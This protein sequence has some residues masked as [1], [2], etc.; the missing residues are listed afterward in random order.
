MPE[1]F[2][3]LLFPLMGVDEG[4]E[5]QMQRM[6]TCKTGTN[7]RSYDMLGFRARGGQRPGLRRF[8]AQSPF[9]ANNNG[10]IFNG[11]PP[12]EGTD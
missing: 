11:P 4:V 5:F 9:D 1:Q 6:G 2:V 10:E 7:V 3:D 12:F 8:F